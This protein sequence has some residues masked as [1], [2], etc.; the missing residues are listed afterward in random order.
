MNNTFFVFKNK[1]QQIIVILLTN[2]TL[3][4]FMPSA[5]QLAKGQDI[6]EIEKKGVQHRIIKHWPL[7]KP[8]PR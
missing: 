8:L 1:I 6:T 3:W 2:R 7:N 5:L 4:F